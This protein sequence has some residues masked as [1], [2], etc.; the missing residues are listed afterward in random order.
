MRLLDFF[1]PPKCIGCRSVIDPHIAE[2]GYGNS[3]FCTTCRSEWEKVKLE[4]CKKCGKVMIECNCRPPLIRDVDGCIKLCK[5]DSSVDA[6]QNKLIFTL[7]HRSFDHAERFVAAQLAALIEDRIEDKENMVLTYIPRKVS[8]KKYYGFDQAFILAKNISKN[9][10]IPLVTCIKRKGGRV[11]KGLSVSERIENSKQS[12][13]PS[14]G[15]TEKALVGTS[16][17]ILDDI[18]T[19]GASMRAAVDIVR[20]MGAERIYCASVA[21]TKRY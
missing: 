3:I 8:S 21:E 6:I 17:V 5:Y 13:I 1:F 2:H 12:F 7:K 15:I 16:V 11:Q 19:S 18:I 4:C 20:S 10:A 14:P 9:L